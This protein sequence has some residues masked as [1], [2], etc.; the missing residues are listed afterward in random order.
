MLRP[1]QRRTD[2]EGREL[3]LQEDTPA[4][5]LVTRPRAEEVSAARVRE[6]VPAIIRRFSSP[7]EAKSADATAF[8]WA[9]RSDADFCRFRLQPM[10]RYRRD[11]LARR[12][13][14]GLL[15]P[16][17]LFARSA[18]WQGLVRRLPAVRS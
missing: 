12:C 10:A 14:E 7:H 15:G 6:F 4:R 5:V 8:Q 1:V 16:L 17:H 9:L 13:D 18:E 2:C 3:L 11:A